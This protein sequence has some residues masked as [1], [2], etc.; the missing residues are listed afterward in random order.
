MPEERVAEEPVDT[1]AQL[2]ADF[3]DFKSTAIAR[4]ARRPTGDMEPTI[5]FTPKE[6]TLFMQGQSV[7]RADYPN[8][9]RWALDNGL[10][11]V[12]SLFTVGDG[13]TTFVLPNMQGRVMLGAGTLGADVYPVGKAAGAAT[14]VILPANMAAHT[15]QVADHMSGSGQ[16]PAEVGSDITSHW[17][18]ISGH[19]GHRYTNFGAAGAP[20][21]VTLADNIDRFDPAH[22]TGNA[23]AAHQH[24]LYIPPHKEVVVGTN[25]PFDVR[26]PY[27]AV[28]WMIWT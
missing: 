23:N 13:S 9:W 8:L 24:Y 7:L 25:T 2:K 3:E 6:D 22:G 18:G 21:Q 17:H 16:T 27:L 12:E 14:K 28:N 20:V 11:G 26:P 15:H 19:G 4:L 10:V 1:L 5:R